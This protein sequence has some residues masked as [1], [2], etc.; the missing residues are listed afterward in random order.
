MLMD[1]SPWSVHPVARL[2]ICGAVALASMASAWSSNLHAQHL[3]RSDLKNYQHVFIIMMENTSYTRLIGN[4]NAPWTNFAAATYGLA[5]DF[6]G[7][8]HPSQP[9]YIAATSGSTNGVT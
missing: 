3:N 7:V 5:T 4:P 6:H 8:T 2:A 9:N 1:R